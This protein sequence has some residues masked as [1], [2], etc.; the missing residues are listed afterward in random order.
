[1]SYVESGASTGLVSPMTALC[2]SS[3][4]LRAPGRAPAPRGWPGPPCS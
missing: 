2:L 1:M 3:P 4:A